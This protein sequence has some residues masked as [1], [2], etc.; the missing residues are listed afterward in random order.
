MLGRTRVGH[1]SESS[2]DHRYGPIAQSAEHRADN[3]GVSGAIP[4]RPTTHSKLVRPNDLLFEIHEPLDQS[5]A[6]D[7]GLSARQY[8][9]VAQ[10]GERLLCKQEVRGSSPLC[11][12]F[13]PARGSSSTFMACPFAWGGVDSP[14]L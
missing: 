2:L 13:L 5:E 6:G 14:A 12:M 8:G 4:L 7:L 9:A 10:L 1:E 3:A 11:S